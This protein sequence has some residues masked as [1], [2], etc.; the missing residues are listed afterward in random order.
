MKTSVMNGEAEPGWMK[1]THNSV[2]T[3]LGFIMWF[4][5]L[6]ALLWSSEFL[7]DDAI[8]S[9]ASPGIYYVGPRADLKSAKVLAGGGD[10]KAI[11][12]HFSLISSI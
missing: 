4:R 6:I 10:N 11:L 5:H 7:K 3:S 12:S 8:S 1:S 9:R 2:Y